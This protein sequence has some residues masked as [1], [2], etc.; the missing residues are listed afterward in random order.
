M[1]EKV[2]RKTIR[3][4]DKCEDI[5]LLILCL[6]VFLIGLYALAD[7]YLVYQHANDSSILKFKPGYEGEEPERP[8]VGNMA[9][10]LTIDDTNIDYPVMQGESNEEYLN[11]DPYGAYS[12]SGSIFLDS[13]NA[14]DF[15]DGYSLIYGH[16]MEGGYMF[17]ALHSFL[18][19]DFFERHRH[20]ELIVGDIAYEIEIFAVLDTEATQAHIFAPTEYRQ[21]EVL[22]YIQK[23]AA[24][25][26]R[27]VCDRREEGKLLG[28]STCKY[29]DSVYRV[30]LF[31]MLTNP[32]KR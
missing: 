20:G 25:C 9:A 23:N 29:P 8:I 14:A 13:R 17:G 4:L 12:L 10:W 22:E 26:D 5:F 24:I 31:G 19:Q 18:E 1:N 15:S 6:L 11:K 28:M 27:T 32:H 16:H 3:M 2:L 21:E 7:S 30:V